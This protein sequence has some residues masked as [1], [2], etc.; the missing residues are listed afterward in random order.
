MDKAYQVISF[1]CFT[2]IEDPALFREAQHLYCLKKNLRGRV[3]IAPE[4]IN[5]KLSGLKQDCQAYLQ[6]LMADPRFASTDVKVDDHTGYASEKLHV[7]LK[8]EIVNAGL[9]HIKPYEKTGIRIT[10]KEFEKMIQADDVIVVD[11]RSDYENNTGRIKGAITFDISN[12]REF[13][14]HVRA[15]EKYKDKRIITTCTGGIKTEKASAYLLSQG[16]KKVYQLQGGLLRYGKE[17]DGSAFEGVCYVFDNRL[18]I[19]INTK[20]PTLIT[21]CYLCQTP[22]KRMVNCAN[23][24]CNRHVP[25]CAPCGEKLQG[26]CSQACQQSSHKRAYNGTGYYTKETNG[27]NP[28]KEARRYTPQGTR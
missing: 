13:P 11:V 20:N 10:P 3:K 23:M 24:A 26:A 18:T 14:A 28:Y 1:Y 7:R 4:G 16:F 21:K 19:D 6:D 15:L 5:G 25:I 12:F 17:T 27:Y 22:S 2:P 9:S 8:R